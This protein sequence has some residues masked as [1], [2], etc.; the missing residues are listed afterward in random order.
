MAVLGVPA[1]ETRHVDFAPLELV[2]AVVV[3]PYDHNSDAPIS[4]ATGAFNF[5]LAFR[6]ERLNGETKAA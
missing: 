1:A 5:A 6:I 2:I 3:D 4:N